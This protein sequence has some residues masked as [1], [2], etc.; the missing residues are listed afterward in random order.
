MKAMSIAVG[1][2]ATGAKPASTAG[3]TGTAHRSV[4]S[5]MSA[6]HE[7]ERQTM[8]RILFPTLIISAVASSAWAQASQETPPDLTVIKADLE[9]IKGDLESVKNQLG[10]VLRQ[11]SQR[12]AQGGV[13]TTAPVHMSVADVPMLGRADAPVTLVEFSDYEC[14]FCQRFL[15]RKSTRL[16]SSHGYISYA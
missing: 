11:L 8:R 15:D 7:R 3:T 5:T 2:I 12:P 14:P 13:G 4:A 1:V 16:N 9:R 10:Q 6:N